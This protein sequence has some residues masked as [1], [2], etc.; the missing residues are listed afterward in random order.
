MRAKLKENHAQR[1]DYQKLENLVKDLRQEIRSK[2]LTIEI[3]KDK[4]KSFEEE[5]IIKTKK[6]QRLENFYSTLKDEQKFNEKRA[7]KEREEIKKR[8]NA[9]LEK[10]KK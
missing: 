4:A 3:L 9:R 5:S 10:Q 8:A 6:I 7:E 2:E 1:S